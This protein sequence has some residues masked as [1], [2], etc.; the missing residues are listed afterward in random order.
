MLGTA[1]VYAAVQT[2]AHVALGLIETRY[3][4]GATAL[5]EG[6]LALA[7]GSAWFSRPVRS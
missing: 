1:V 7:V 5:L 3:L 2:I 6:S 4:L